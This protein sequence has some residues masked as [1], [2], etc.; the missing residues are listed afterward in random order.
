MS[1][2]Q[3]SCTYRTRGWV[4]PRDDVDV[5][6][7]LYLPNKRLSESQRQCRCSSL[8]VPTEQEAEWVPG[9]MWMFQFSCTYRTR[10]WVS[11]RDDVDVLVFL[12]LPN[13][14]LSESQRRCGCSSFLVPTE[15]EAEWVPGTMSMFQFSYSF[16]IK[17]SR[18][19]VFFHLPW[20]SHCREKKFV[21]SFSVAFHSFLI[22][23]VLF[24]ILME[25]NTLQ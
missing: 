23:S 14:R 9:T 21:C 3:F 2:F 5:P 7:F 17:I 20:V 11:P 16:F 13:K 19:N 24:G 22:F 4:S 6:V 15:Q 25:A 12:Y 10:G 8:L 1:M 18:S